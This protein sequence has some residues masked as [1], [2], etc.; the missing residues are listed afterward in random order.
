LKHRRI[1]DRG[2]PEEARLTLLP[3]PLKRRH[4]I[5]EDFSDT[6]RVPATGV[7]DRVVQMED[8]DMIAAHATG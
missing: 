6:E 2:Q 8:V 5:V 3:Q 1:A 4:H 7:G